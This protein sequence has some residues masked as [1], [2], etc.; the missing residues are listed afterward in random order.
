MAKCQRPKRSRVMKRRVK[1]LTA[2]AEAKRLS[3]RCGRRRITEALSR[4]FHFHHDAQPRSQQEWF[5]VD[6]CSVTPAELASPFRYSGEATSSCDGIVSALFSLSMLQKHPSSAE[7]GTCRDQRARVTVGSLRLQMLLSLQTS[8]VTRES[9]TP[10]AILHAA[11]G[12]LEYP[13]VL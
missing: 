10:L 9:V 13:S 5:D 3:D 2:A 12:I 11:W 1:I 4:G 6:Y 7:L 8:H